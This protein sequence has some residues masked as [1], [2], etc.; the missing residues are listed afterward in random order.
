MH[1]GLGASEVKEAFIWG[2]S[3]YQKW[4]SGEVVGEESVKQ[5][6]V[7]GEGQA[8]IAPLSRPKAQGSVTWTSAAMLAILQCLVQPQMG[9]ETEGERALR[10]RHVSHA[11]WRLCMTLKTT[12]LKRGSAHFHWPGD[13]TD[14]SLNRL[15]QGWRSAESGNF[16][17]LWAGV[18]LLSEVTGVTGSSAWPSVSRQPMV[19]KLWPV[20]SSVYCL[21]CSH[22]RLLLFSWHSLTPITLQAL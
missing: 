6:I 9:R 17:M 11:A 7:L 4:I 10:V 22:H 18:Q 12:L 13:R 2:T 8:A 15:N 16:S 20:S 5:E 14:L 19:T 1:D 3:S 21:A